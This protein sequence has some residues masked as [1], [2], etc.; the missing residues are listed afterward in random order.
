MRN[1]LSEET[2]VV[3]NRA[4]ASPPKRRVLFSLPSLRVSELQLPWVEV[5]K[6]VMEALLEKLRAG[7]S[8]R[9][10]RIAPWGKPNASQ[11][12]QRPPEAQ[13]SL[14]VHWPYCEKRCSYCNFNKYIPRNLDE[15]RMK[16]CL[17]QEVQTLI[18][19]SEVQRITSVY[20]GGGTPSLAS[21]LTIDAIL[22]TVSQC[23]HLAEGAEV[24]LEA[25]PASADA[26]CLS[27][28]QKA[29]VN[30]L[31]IGIQSLDNGELKLLGRNHTACDAL[32][33]LEEAKKLFPGRTSIDLIFGLPGQT[34]ASW[35]QGLEKALAVCDDHISLYQLTLERGTSLFKQVHQGFLPPINVD[36]VSEMY[37]CARHVLQNS[38]FY[39]YEVSNF[40]KNGAFSTHN[41]S[42]WQGSQYIGIGPGAHG[43][44]V[45]RGDGKIHREARIQTL[46]PDIWMKEV[47]A[48]GHGTRKQTPLR[49]LDI[50]EEVLILGLRMDVGITHQHWLQFATSL[51][52]WDVFGEAKEVKELEEHGFIFLD[53]RGLRCSWKGLAVL[54]SL[55]LRLLKQL[56]QTWMER[57]RRM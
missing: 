12:H 34:V 23:T 19:L 32:R 11:L 13:A 21:P 18:H 46:E 48:F 25:N 38:G 6:S 7:L 47:L 49:E 31:S 20:F 17:I 9:L 16:N 4:E 14:Y 50:L 41:L 22:D 45:P 42:Y 53:D 44:F 55:L 36:I 3:P 57:E 28:F 56:Q 2:R 30:R 26:L 39:Q 33:T 52:L 15:L 43:R 24:T 35:A 29:G 10:G 40:S 8:A 51:S 1:S 5:A 27:K 54:D 37:E